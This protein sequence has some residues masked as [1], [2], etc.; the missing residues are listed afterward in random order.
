V[1]DDAVYLALGANLGERER[2]VLGALRRLGTAGAATVVRCSGLY[3]CAAV[4]MGEAPRF[5][6]AVAEVRALLPP[7][8]LLS[9]LKTIEKEMGRQ[10]GH[11]APREIDI[12]IV[13]WGAR[14]GRWPGL[15]VP[16]PLYA[17][18]PF[19]LVP[20]GEIAPRFTCPVTGAPIGQMIREAGGAT[21][22]MRVS[23]RRLVPAA[24]P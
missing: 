1:A 14:V 24:I 15:V 21:G 3:E 11:N 9:R 4:G 22:V 19:V 17:T 20:L 7:P 23:E 18:R 6:N 10:A 2:R 8:D 5:I 12:D 13:A 16:H